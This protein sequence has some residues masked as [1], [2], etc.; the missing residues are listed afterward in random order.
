MSAKPKIE[1]N[2]KNS[3]VG[4]LTA[5]DV[6]DVENILANVGTLASK[7]HDEVA[8]SLKEVT[9]AVASSREL[10]EQERTDVLDSLDEIARQAALPVDRRAKPGVIKSVLSGIAG[11][12]AAAGG[13]AEVWSTW[14]P[15]ITRFFGL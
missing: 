3:T 5:G 7:G 1:I 10:S 6:K 12:L 11:S 14:G 4:M 9:E 13:T 8:T 15:Q 2:L